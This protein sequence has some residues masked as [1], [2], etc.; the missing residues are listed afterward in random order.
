MA[1]DPEGY[2]PRSGLAAA[3]SGGGDHAEACALLE[4]LR[5]D[6]P[7]DASVHRRLVSEHL[8]LRR[9][10]PALVSAREAV[11]LDPDDAHGHALYGLALY[12]VGD[13]P[14]AEA[15]L[16]HAIAL[17]AGDAGALALLGQILVDRGQVDEAARLA[18]AAV[19]IDP[20]ATP[21][22]LLQGELAWTRGDHAAAAELAL[23]GLADDPEDRGLRLLLIKA[24]SRRQP[25][26]AHAL[27]MHARR[28]ALSGGAQL[29]LVFAVTAVTLLF[30]AYAGRWLGVT[31]TIA[32]TVAWGA[33]VAYVFWLAPSLIDE[34]L[35]QAE[36]KV[37][38]G[39]TF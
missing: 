25:W 17:D 2:E 20:Q 35:R 1:G 18:A 22:I 29:A 11:A 9:T 19:Q 6:A 34:R 7:D 8:A 39:P 31:P 28:D 36:R 32:L 24:E 12:A 5:A 14:A 33:Y 30:P 15:A 3:L 26:A 23:W 37:R 10:G 21:V 13:Q 16:R 4:S 27:R 38:L